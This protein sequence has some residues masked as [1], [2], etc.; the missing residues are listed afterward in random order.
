MI[1]NTLAIQPELRLLTEAPVDSWGLVWTQVESLNFLNLVLKIQLTLLGKRVHTVNFTVWTLH[2]LRA[3]KSIKQKSFLMSLSREFWSIL[4]LKIL[5]LTIQLWIVIH[6]L[7]TQ[8]IS[9]CS[10]SPFDDC[11]DEVIRMSP[12]VTLSRRPDKV[13]VSSVRIPHIRGPPY[14]LHNTK[15]AEL[16]DEK[17]WNQRNQWT[18]DF[19]F[20]SK[21]IFVCR[22][23]GWS[24][25]L[26]P[27]RSKSVT[28]TFHYLISQSQIANLRISQF[29]GLGA[30]HCLLGYLNHR[31]LNLLKLL[32]DL[33]R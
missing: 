9:T 21:L 31:L 13:D 30:T 23:A 5:V 10:D 8:I 16:F 4:L 26:L 25:D 3:L 20:L 2:I 7:W 1:S 17:W 32:P 27:E 28:L 22:S 15:G 33:R 29:R 11:S 6:N 24:G 19:R 14:R 12:T 18:D